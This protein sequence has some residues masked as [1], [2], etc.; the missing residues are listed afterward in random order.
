MPVTVFSASRSAHPG[1]A[2]GNQSNS[3]MIALADGGYVVVWQDDA[4]LGSKVLMQRFD[5]QGVAKGS[6]IDTGLTGTVH[7]I[8]MTAN[9]AIAIATSTASALTVTFLS[10]TTLGVL[11]ASGVGLTTPLSSVQIDAS[12]GDTMRLMVVDTSGTIGTTT[13]VLGSSIPSPTALTNGGA[14]AK[15]VELTGTGTGSIDFGLVTGG[16]GGTIVGTSG[17]TNTGFNLNSA[18]DLIQLQPGVYVAAV[19]NAGATGL[20]YQALFASPG[21]TDPSALVPVATEIIGQVI[22]NPNGGS[23]TGAAVGTAEMVNLGDGR[24]L[25]IWSAFRG[26]GTSTAQSGIYAAVMNMLSGTQEGDLV[27]LDSLSTLAEV[28]SAR[29]TGRVMADGRVAISYTSRQIGFTGTD[30]RQAILD[31]RIA[32]ITVSGT[33]AADVFVGTALADSFLA[34]SDTDR[35]DGGAGVDSVTLTGSASRQID[36]ATPDAFPTGGPELIAIEN[37]TGGVGNDTI[38]GSTAANVLDGGNGNDLLEGRTG[39]DTLRGGSGNDVA[40]GGDG[41]DS[42]DGGVG[43]DQ[44]S[45]G[46]GNDIA[47][48]GT[49]DDTIFGQG[50]DDNLQGG[51]DND[52]LFGGDGN[53]TIFGGTGNDT[54]RGGDGEDRL[55]GDDGNDLI[56]V[57]TGTALVNG[58]LGTDTAS[59]NDIAPGPSFSGIYA[60]LTNASDPLALARGFEAQEV[61]FTAI[62][63]LTGSLGKDFL[64]GDDAAN[65]LRGLAE[66]DVL[67]GRAGNDTLIGGDGADVFLFISGTSGGN[68]ISDYRVG[69]DRIGLVLEAFGDIDAGNIAARFTASATAAPAANANAQMLFDN[70]GG[71]A[72]RL[73]FDADG[74]GAG[75]ALQ[76]AV[77][78]FSTPDGLT[79]FGAG[80]FVFF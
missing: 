4:A 34:I 28:Q 22:P 10:A 68:V 20:R 42:L 75:A 25:A 38:L 54:L 3:G 11:G 18:L 64:A 55:I 73:F 12:G 9:G 52:R 70:S 65:V 57:G 59:Y 66:D 15:V 5:G 45:G 58:G 71:G 51:A 21:V 33:T 79:T 48:G 80:D 27:Q 8:E 6:V 61:M 17:G 44:V 47:L 35:I 36:L 41:N 26:T 46:A 24:V 56:F 67:M 23:L 14:G 19:A 62:E 40:F 69:S 39:N 13:A 63:N 76:I 77:L 29:I 43:A 50:G 60:D 49:G 37:V 16:S 31:P 30:T 53:D 7:D 1:Q 74:N 2:F 72:G 32:G 78:R